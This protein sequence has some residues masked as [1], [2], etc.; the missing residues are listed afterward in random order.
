VKRG[1]SRDEACDLA[2][3]VLREIWEIVR[4]H[5]D[6]SSQQESFLIP[7]HDARRLNPEWWRIRP[8]SEDERVFLCNT[9]G[10][11]QS[12]SVSGV[13]ARHR[14]P[15]SLREIWKGEMEANHYRCLYEDTLPGILRSEEHT[16]QIEKEKARIFQRAFK[17]GEIHV[18]SSST[19]FELGVDLGDLDTIF[20]RNVP[21]EAF[22]Y[23]QRVGRAGRRSGYPG[24]AV[25][26][27]K[28]GSHDLYHFADPLTMITGKVRPPCLS[29]C[30][31]KI[32]IR[33]ITATALSHFFRHNPERFNNAL[34]LFGDLE[35]PLG[36]KDFRDHV[37]SHMKELE[38]TLTD[39]VPP[40]IAGSVGLTDGTW[41]DKVA[42]GESRLS[43]AEAEI[44]SD[45]KAVRELEK[46]LS[47][48]S[49]KWRTEPL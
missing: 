30:N 29:I 9:C 45:Y 14:C 42:G 19:T 21:P 12:V 34:S 44:S 1:V 36:L 49:W 13:C 10:R 38:T 15:G 27:C 35:R 23:T 8:I 7:A 4:S 46:K 33:H 18:L 16:A 28:R 31:E 22:N 3:N 26:F 43:F 6:G 48:P 41:I 2:V 17:S 32:A 37:C 24:F 25:T 11:L 40:S 20:L 47:C 5:E 39:I